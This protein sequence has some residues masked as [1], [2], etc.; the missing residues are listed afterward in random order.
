MSFDNRAPSWAPDACALSAAERPLRSAEF[1][2]L[3]AGSLRAGRTRPACLRSRRTAV[4]T[5]R[6]RG[7]A[8]LPIFFETLG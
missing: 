3:F 7:R 6:L 8:P 5:E 4:V 1:S 2:T